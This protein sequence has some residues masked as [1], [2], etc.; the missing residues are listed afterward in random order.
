[1]IIK[2]YSI[3]MDIYITTSYVIIK[4]VVRNH[5]YTPFINFKDPRWKLV[6]VG[7]GSGN[8]RFSPH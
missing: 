8:T 4:I 5:N 7:W 2:L 1:M 6:L 3:K